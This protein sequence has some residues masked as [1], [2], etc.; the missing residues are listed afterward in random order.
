MSGKARYRLVNNMIPP[1]RPAIVRSVE[2]SEPLVKVGDIVKHPK[3][4]IGLV[5]GAGKIPGFMSRGSMHDPRIVSVFSVM[6]CDGHVDEGWPAA[7]LANFVC[8]SRGVNI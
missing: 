4:G 3:Y 1:D 2:D 8:T 6:W 5:V 7:R